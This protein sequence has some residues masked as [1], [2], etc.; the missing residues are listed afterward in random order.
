VLFSPFA[1]FAF[2]SL[3]CL[4]NQN[5][6]LSLQIFQQLALFFVAVESLFQLLSK[7]LNHSSKAPNVLLR[8]EVFSS[9][10][11]ELFFQCVTGGGIVQNY[12]TIYSSVIGT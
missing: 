4:S 3:F 8:L 11:F 12:T 5:V 10:A 2:V 1:V 9:Q 7:V 6:E